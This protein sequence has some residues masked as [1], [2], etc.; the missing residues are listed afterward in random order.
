MFR[1]TM[2]A[3]V[4]ATVGTALISTDA[5]AQGRG[6]GFHGGGGIGRIG[7]GMGHFGGGM[8]RIG[9]GPIA[10]GGAVTRGTTAFAAMTG[11]PRFGGP[12]F[13]GFGPRFAG[14]PWR[15]GW[16]RRGLGIGLGVG[17]GLAS[18]AAW[19]PWGWGGGWSDPGWSYAAWDG[20]YGGWDSGWGGCTRLRRV[21]TGFGFRLVPVNVCW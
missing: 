6:G 17:L 20:G 19:S 10:G 12:R 1:K 15:G 21:W 5:S 8:G 11:G 16:H 13:G 14:G 7:G 4:V 3:L 9:G 2:I 18:A